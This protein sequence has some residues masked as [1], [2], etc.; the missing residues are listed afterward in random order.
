[1]IGGIIG[2]DIGYVR[3]HNYLGALLG[4]LLGTVIT[5]LLLSIRIVTVWA[6]G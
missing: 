4:G 6:G 5:L 1:L 3:N 2:G